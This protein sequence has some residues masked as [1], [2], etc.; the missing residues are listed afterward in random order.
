M[1]AGMGIFENKKK[2]IPRKF[3]MI[4]LIMKSWIKGSFNN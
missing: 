2:I 1:P 4:T 3:Y